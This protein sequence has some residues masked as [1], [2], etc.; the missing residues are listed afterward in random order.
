[1]L[2]VSSDECGS[3]GDDVRLVLMPLND[4]RVSSSASIEAANGSMDG[5]STSAASGGM[6]DR[7]TKGTG[8]GTKGAMEEAKGGEGGREREA[9]MGESVTVAMD[10]E[11]EWE[12][13]N[14][15]SG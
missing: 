13:S 14:S 1:M 5:G 15:D 9:G 12:C 2:F 11:R 6:E 10:G 7:D 8:G 4:C 3:R